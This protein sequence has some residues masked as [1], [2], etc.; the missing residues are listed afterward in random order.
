MAEFDSGAAGREARTFFEGLWSDSDPWD[1][2]ASDLDQRRYE[3]QLDLL[4]DRRYARALEIGC[5]AGAFTRRVAS[6]CDRVVALDVADAA[7]ARAR[8]DTPESTS[9]EY[10]RANVMEL[11]ISAEGAWDLVILTETA[12]YVGWLYPMF[13]IGWLAHSL[14]EA[15]RPDGRLLLANTIWADEGIMSP[16]LIRT[17]RDL[18]R[19]VGYELEAEEEMR[20]V[21]ETVEFDILIS[22]FTKRG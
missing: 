4:S 3:R 15:T 18:F 8:A 13:D 16:W 9:I 7:I 21:K 1:L 22:L 17:Y 19:N 12:Y 2:S 14:H 10:R 20:G 6:L 11:D 5:A